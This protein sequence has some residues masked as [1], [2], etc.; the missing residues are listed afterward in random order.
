MSEDQQLAEESVLTKWQQHRFLMLIVLTIIISFFLVGIALALYNSSG[1][2][3]LDL[4]GPRF[5]SVQ[6][7]ATQDDDFNGFPASGDLD[8]NAFNQFQSEYS[9]QTK[10]VTDVD[11]FSGDVMSDQ[12]LSID[13]P[14]EQ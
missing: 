2:A 6:K 11:S 7:Q 14:A 3:Q 13:P 10:K 1:A 4:S 5:Q 12:A 9:K 8:Q